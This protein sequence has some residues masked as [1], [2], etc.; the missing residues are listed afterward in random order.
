MDWCLAVSPDHFLHFVDALGN[1][2]CEGNAA[3]TRRLAAV[4]Q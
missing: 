2:H 4:T 1:V 3:L